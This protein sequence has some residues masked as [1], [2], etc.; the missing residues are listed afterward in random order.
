[1]S[2]PEVTA[3]IIAGLVAALLVGYIAALV[4]FKIK[5]RWCPQ[6]GSTTARLCHQ[7][8]TP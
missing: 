3:M 4:Y 7:V 6:C 5:N 1:V 2:A 8:T